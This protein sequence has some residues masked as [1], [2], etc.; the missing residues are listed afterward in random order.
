M[1]AA[2]TVMEPAGDR[3]T[4]PWSAGWRFP[5]PISGTA[6]VKTKFPRPRIIRPVENRPTAHAPS[7]FSSTPSRQ[8]G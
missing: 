8:Y 6:V 1:T 5:V 3:F 4:P 2:R 7:Q